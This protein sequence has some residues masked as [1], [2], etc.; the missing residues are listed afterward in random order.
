MKRKALS[1]TQIL[2]ISCDNASANDKM[3]DELQD[4]LPE[5]GGRA[6]HTRCFLHTTNLIAKA[7]LSQ[8]DVKKG[9]AIENEDANESVEDDEQETMAETVSID[10]EGEGD[11]TKG[12]IDLT[13]EMDPTERVAH[14]KSVRPVKLVLVKVI[15]FIMHAPSLIHPVS[16]FAR[17]HSRL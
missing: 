8:F 5:F 16:S 13:D 17:W 9:R 2:S 14:A 15:V 6:S 7:L 3:I 4:M 1:V 11:N 10:A 12:F